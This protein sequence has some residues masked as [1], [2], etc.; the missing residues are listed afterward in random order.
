MAARILG[1]AQVEQLLPMDQCIR[2]VRAGLMALSQGDALSPLRQIMDL[3]EQGAVLGL[4]PGWLGH[5][6]CFG[7]KVTSVY[8]ENHRRGLPSH[9][10]LIVVF[11]AQDGR[12][13]GAVDGGAVTAIRT[14]AASAVA[15][16]ALARADAHRL[17]ILGYGAQ[18]TTHLEA[19]RLVRNIDW[20]RVWG[21]DPGKAQAFA[22]AASMRFEVPVQAASDPAS[23]VANADIICTVT[24]ATDPILLGCDVPAGAHLNV[25]GSSR[26]REAEIDAALVRRARLFADYRP[27]LLAQG[28]E[29]LR[30]KAAGIVDDGHVLGE[31]G[32][33][34][35]GRILGRETHSDVT[36]YKSLGHIVEDLVSAAHVLEAAA[37]CGIGAEVSL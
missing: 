7:V 28:G 16:E 36:I 32:E 19:M 15:T 24:A 23:C 26:A 12:V 25:V 5:P 34:L 21:R 3:P 30:A 6:S 22:H 2:C 20:V 13:L 8:P 10:G 35:L 37:R 27:G 11:D 14:A 31:L 18:A 17:A 9:Q 1:K 29:F 33:V 4:M